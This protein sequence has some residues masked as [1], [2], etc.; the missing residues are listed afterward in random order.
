MFTLERHRFSSFPINSQFQADTSIS[1][2]S[3]LEKSLRYYDLHSHCL[4]QLEIPFL[5]S[6]LSMVI[7]FST[8]HYPLVAST[9]VG[10]YASF[11]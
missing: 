1:L 9:L 6:M 11:Y 4:S 8:F 5:K 3:P 7:V 10:F 2:L